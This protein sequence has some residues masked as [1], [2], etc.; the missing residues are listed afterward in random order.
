MKLFFQ[1]ILVFV[2][3]TILNTHASENSTIDLTQTLKLDRAFE[4]TRYILTP[5]KKA[6]KIFQESIDKIN[7]ECC[8]EDFK[9]KAK[10]EEI[11][12]ILQ[13][14]LDKNCER[15]AIPIF[16]SKKPPQ[17]LVAFRLIPE[18]DNLILENENFK[19]KKL[20]LQFDANRSEKLKNEK[21]LDILKKSIKEL[22]NENSKLKKTV[23]KMLKNYQGKISKL[24]KNNS[25]LKD[26][27]QK[28][29][30]MLPKTKQKKFKK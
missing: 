9:Q 7:T 17:K 18:I 2:F 25:E 27:F 5:A 24:E 10:I 28:A 8:D 6:K 30:E 12:N 13:S 16:N 22:E 3:S 29:F 23:D 14:C 19:Y 20:T 1:V 26:D 21:N 15:Y 4:N 11:K